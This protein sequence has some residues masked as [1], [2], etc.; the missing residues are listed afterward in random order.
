[1]CAFRAKHVHLSASEA[2]SEDEDVASERGRVSSGD[3]ADDV[4]VMQDLTKVRLFAAFEFIIT[5]STTNLG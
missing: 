2:E 4:L 3:V 1:V 5:L